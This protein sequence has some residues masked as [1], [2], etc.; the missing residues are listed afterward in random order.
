MRAALADTPVVL[1][2]GARHTGKT[3]LSRH[4]VEA[5]LGC[6]YLTF[7]DATQLAAASADPRGF[8]ST[9]GPCTVIDEV[10]KVPALFPAI[11]AIVDMDRRPGRLL[12]TGSANVLLVPRLSESL[13]GRIELL[14]LWPLSQ[15]ELSGR[16][17]RFIDAAFAPH[18]SASLVADRAGPP[19]AARILGGGFPEPLERTDPARRAAWFTSYLSTTLQ[20][21]IRDLANIEGWADLPRLLALLAS[22]TSGLLNFSDLS[23]GLSMPL[24]TLKR[25]LALLEATFMVVTIPAWSSNA[26]LR[27]TKSP[28]LMVA[29]TGLACH[30]LG[31]DE[32]RLARD[33]TARGALLEN[34]VAMELM[35]QATWSATRVRLFHMRTPAGKEVDLVLEDAAGRIVGIE[36]K[37]AATVNADDFKGLRALREMAGAKFIRGIVLHDGDTT[38]PFEPNLVAMP[39]ATLWVA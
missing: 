25:Y 2:H 36:V 5:T 17:E 24:T 39:L 21:D 8:L 18:V 30:L 12:L 4:L 6:S 37:S 9:L 7:D 35:K 23:R 15:G 34:F 19:L 26:G 22:R 29:D 10:Q 38:V 20:R 1:V 27:L 14:T 11:K 16:V 3:T 13:A 31:M 32:A 28:K 33:G